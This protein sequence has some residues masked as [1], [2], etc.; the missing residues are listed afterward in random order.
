MKNRVLYDFK[1]VS[2]EKFKF[3]VGR[4]IKIVCDFSAGLPMYLEFRYKNNWSDQVLLLHLLL[5]LGTDKRFIEDYKVKEAIKTGIHYHLDSFSTAQWFWGPLPSGQ[6]G[7]MAND[8]TPEFKED[9]AVQ[10]M[11]SLFESFLPGD[12]CPKVVNWENKTEKELM[13]ATCDGKSD[14]H[15]NMMYRLSLFPPSSRGNQVKKHLAFMYLQIMLGIQDVVVLPCVDACELAEIPELCDQKNT[16]YRIIA[17]KDRAN[18]GLLASI[19][20]LYDII[21]GHEPLLDFT[22]GT[23]DSI[24]KLKKDVLE[25]LIKR[26]STSHNIN[27][28]DSKTIRKIMFSEYLDMVN[29]R[30]E[31][32]LQN[33]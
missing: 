15:L 16:F 4:F 25:W 6:S 22:E 11:V 3:A 12:Q 23:R 29:M 21:V 10:S 1:A 20:E 2:E 14:H 27:L 24:L 7:N 33:V 8:G 19:V 30:W 5:L 18:Y 26:F 9:N 13:V 17:N 32:W 28:S 31:S